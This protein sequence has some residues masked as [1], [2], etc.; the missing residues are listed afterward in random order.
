MITNNYNS[1][2]EKKK[3]AIILTWIIIA[4]LFIAW[5]VTPPGNKIVQILFWGNNTQL[6]FAKLTNNAETKEWKLHRNSAVYSAKINKREQSLAEMEKAVQTFPAYLSDKLL[7]NLYKDKAT[8]EMYYEEY[9][10][11]LTDYLKAKNF[12][13]TDKFRIAMLLSKKERHAE[14][15]RWCNDIVNIDSTAYAGYSCLAEVYSVAGRGDVSIR[16]FDLL[17]DRQPNKARYYA[18]RA[19][20]K[21]KLGDMGGF[22]EDMQKAK[23]ISPS[24]DPEDTMIKTI[25]EPKV[26]QL[27]AI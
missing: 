8:L 19:V 1:K 3:D 26:L 17:I 24:I 16:V 25:L 5:L 22:D 20:Y 10:K 27:D 7:Q 2:E 12:T 21:R 4:F 9:D 11:A 6:F 18:D 23:A 15:L 14:A 13:I